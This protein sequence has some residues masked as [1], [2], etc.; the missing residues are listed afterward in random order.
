LWEGKTKL[1]ATPDRSIEQFG[2]VRCRKGD[3]ITWQLIYLHKQERDNALYLPSF[4]TVASLLSN[5]IELVKEQHAWNGSRVI[6][7]ARKPGIRFAKI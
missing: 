6:E 7:E 3:D 1:K 5:G 2:V 4:V